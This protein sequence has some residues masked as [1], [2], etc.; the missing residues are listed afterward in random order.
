VPDRH[1]DPPN[2][3]VRR[4][5]LDYAIGPQ[6][7]PNWLGSLADEIS[8]IGVLYELTPDRLR[9]TS[10]ADALA[11]VL[12]FEAVDRHRPMLKVEFT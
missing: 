10:A 5:M 9:I 1:L 7:D 8:E 2:A 4:D 11:V 12:V 6:G 3:I